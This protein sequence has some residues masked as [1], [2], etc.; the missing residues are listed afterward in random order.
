MQ[1]LL[2][3]VGNIATG[4]STLVQ[5]LAAEL[6]VPVEPERWSENPFLP[7]A[8]RDPERYAP[9]AEI[10]FV[11]NA[12]AS[13]A[14]LEAIGGGILERPVQEHLEVFVADRAEAGQLSPEDV[15]ALHHVGAV[16]RRTLREPDLVIALHAPAEELRRRIVSRGVPFEQSLTV[17]DLERLAERYRQLAAH[18]TSPVLDL[19]TTT[20]DVRR[21]D[22][23]QEVARR[24]RQ[25]LT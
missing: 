1:P 14:H 15:A 24:V 21:P 22:G 13:Q 19:D 9:A 4:K 2:A 6:R 23:L 17:S 25:R 18:T 7:D 3:V 20:I 11:T 10:W 12:A 16:L 5:A 8:Q